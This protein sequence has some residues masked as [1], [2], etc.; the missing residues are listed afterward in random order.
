MKNHIEALQLLTSCCDTS[1][2]VFIHSWRALTKRHLPEHWNLKSKT[3]RCGVDQEEH[4]HSSGVSVTPPCL[5]FTFKRISFS[6]FVTGRACGWTVAKVWFDWL[7]FFLAFAHH[8]YEG[9]K[10]H[11]ACHCHPSVKG[12]HF[13]VMS[14]VLPIVHDWIFKIETN[15]SFKQIIKFPTLLT[16]RLSDTFC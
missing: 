7:P 6:C 16:E 8:G 15:V 1:E 3:K 5:W 4:G 14:L 10:M 11:P 9:N 13:Q 12:L 2:Y